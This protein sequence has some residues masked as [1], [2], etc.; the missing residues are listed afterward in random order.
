M[1]RFKK[2]WVTIC[3]VGCAILCCVACKEKRVVQSIVLNEYSAEKPLEL[4]VGKFSYDYTVTITYDN[5]ETEEVPLTE[6]M[7]SETDKLKFY[8]EGK[9]EIAIT[10]QGISIPV[11]IMVSRSDFP[12]SVKLNN[13]TVPYDG[14][15]YSVEVEGE[16]PGGTEI[17]YP[18]GN[19]FQ[20]AGSYD[21]TAI[22]QCDGYVTKTLSA[23]VVIEKASYDEQ[24]FDAKLYD[25]TVVY[26]QD[27]YSVF[28]KGKAIDKENENDKTEY[29]PAL[30]PQGVSVSY[31][32]TKIKDGKGV[33]IPKEKQ[34]CIEGNKAVEAGTYEVRAQ[35]KG[36]VVNY[37]AIPDSVAHL[38]IK[39]A[40]YNL[41]K[42]EFSDA[43]VTYSGEVH[44][45]SLSNEKAMPFDVQVSYAIKQIKD[46]KG[47]KVEDK[48]QKGNKAINAGVYSVE[49][50]FTIIGKNAEN[51]TTSLEKKTA[52]LTILP[53]SYDEIIN[54]LYL[55]SQWYEWKAGQT[56]QIFFDGEL[57]QGVS[58]QFVLTNEL[59][60]KI[61]GTME[62]VT[63][64][65]GEGDKAIVKTEYQYS[66]TAETPGEYACV[67]TFVHSNM[68][69][70]DITVKLTAWVIL[71]SEA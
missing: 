24:V 27:A 26:N 16:I 46:G 65:E 48:F 41:S 10:Y 60:E 68:N 45:L 33:E 25:E 11:A 3:L 18:Q 13:L 62:K 53:A 5:G 23:K 9:N 15:I 36:D 29:Q 54:D 51:Y 64:T 59:G 61:E 47:N 42:V 58:P 34:Q 6:D 8:Y 67:I 21:M 14:T 28:V 49:A 57:P 71:T 56:Y 66:F 50:V 39:R 35:F 44:S 22:L 4:F 37:N 63:K 32:I 38:T 30:I 55:N 17:L 40:E 7:I 69:Y 52:N 43:T 1:I 20:N 2:I 31:M 12:D 19:T 70:A